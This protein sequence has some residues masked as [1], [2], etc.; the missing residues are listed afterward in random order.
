MKAVLDLKADTVIETAKEAAKTIINLIAPKIKVEIVGEAAQDTKVNIAEEAADAEISTKVSMEIFVKANANIEI[1]EGGEESVIRKDENITVETNNKTDAEIITSD[2]AGN[3]TSVVKP[4]E[5][6]TETTTPAPTAEP[7]PTVN[8]GSGSGSGGSIPAPVPTTNPNP[9][10]TPTPTATTT[11]TP[12]PASGSAWFLYTIEGTDNRSSACDENYNIIIQLSKNEIGKKLQFIGAGAEN[13]EKY[14]IS[15]EM[16]VVEEGTHQVEVTMTAKD[17]PANK[18][19][20]K[21]TVTAQQVP[22]FDGYPVYFIEG[23]QSGVALQEEFTDFNAVPVMKNDIGKKLSLRPVLGS[24]DSQNYILT[25]DPQEVVVQDGETKVNIT[26]TAKDNPENKVT[27]TVTFIVKPVP[28]FTG[29]LN[30]RFEDFTGEYGNEIN[31]LI[32]LSKNDS[33]RT[34]RFISDRFYQISPETITIEEGTHQVDVTITAKDNPENKVVR[35]ITIIAQEI[36]AFDGSLSYSIEGENEAL[37]FSLE[38]TVGTAT[39]MKGDIGKKID[40]SVWSENYESRY[41]MVT[42]DPQEP[43]V[44]DGET[45]VNVTVAPKDNPE[46]K[47]VYTVTFTVEPIPEFNGSFHLEG[48]NHYFIRLWDNNAYLSKSE[49]GKKFQIEGAGRF[50]RISPETIVIQEGTNTVD[51]TITAKDDP[52]NQVVR[53][54]TIT[55]KEVPA[56]EGSLGYQLEGEKENYWQGL[57]FK[58]NIAAVTLMKGD[59]GKKIKFDCWSERYDSRYY[60]LTTDLLEP[61]VLDGET[62]VIL[63]ITAKDDPE[64]KVVYTITFTISDPSQDLP[65]PDV[66]VTS[67]DPDAVTTLSNGVVVVS[68]S[69]IDVPL[70]A[71]LSGENASKWSIVSYTWYEAESEDAEGTEI[72]GNT[73][74]VCQVSVEENKKMYYYVKIK[75]KPVDYPDAEEKEIISKKSTDI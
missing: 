74:S 18:V 10:A 42:T 6:T 14:Q 31:G 68:G 27:Y 8:P 34:F 41:Y 26:I 33:G 1:G 30:Y 56:F 11:P 53:T 9:T 5:S 38:D 35:T 54:I 29:S 23:D 24:Y 47:V 4:G 50:Y 51:I 39:L 55:A 75:V 52:A 64:N 19:V 28:E 60:M 62:K 46:N 22:A 7:V 48:A 20:Y 57:S 17:N 58:E 73:E 44:L 16:I 12:T 49:I 63:T 69:A 3:H 45:K 15:P 70:A 25:T 59:I 71:E 13:K 40:F 43:V 36:P 66:S 37:S 67:S 2:L 72:A 21:V 65:L 32:R 61:I